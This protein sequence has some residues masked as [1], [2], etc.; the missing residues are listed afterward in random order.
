[1]AAP[2]PYVNSPTQVF[3]ASNWRED[4]RNGSP[5]GAGMFGAN[6]GECDLVCTVDFNRSIPAQRFFLGYATVTNQASPDADVKYLGDPS[7]SGPYF[8]NRTP[9]VYHP[10]YPRC[11]CISVACEDYVPNGRTIRAG[12]RTAKIVETAL[13]A[14]ADGVPGWKATIQGKS[15]GYMT[16]YSKSRLTARFAPTEFPM[17]TDTNVLNPLDSTE[18]QEW[19]RW[20]IVTQT[21]T[22]DVLT[23]DGFQLL[24]TEGT[25]NTG[26]I[27]NPYLNKT[28]SS[29]GQVL[30]ISDV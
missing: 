7:T 1:M 6:G 23:L 9:P 10:R 16:A 2:D 28:K 15:L 26:D 3:T 24:Y 22:M 5:N 13:P 30:V 27:S 11:T 8:L 17:L 21:P 20:T 25:G 19:R 4:L 12:K 29:I 18:S 14:L